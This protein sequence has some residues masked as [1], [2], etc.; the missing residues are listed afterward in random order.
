MRFIDAEKFIE[1]VNKDREH[2]CYLHSWTADDVLERLDSWYAPTVDA[3]TK[4]DYESRL[5]ADLVAILEEIRLE[6]TKMKDSQVNS[7][8][9]E[10]YDFIVKR[11]IDE[12]K[13][14]EDGKD[15]N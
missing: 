12:L 13:G 15:D 8:F 9:W 14:E 11:R 4:V 1:K 6:A 3:I 7:Y 5:K 10:N 2:E